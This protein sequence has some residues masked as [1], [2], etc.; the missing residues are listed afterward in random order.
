MYRGHTFR[1]RADR[2][3]ARRFS[4]QAILVSLLI[5]GV[6][7]FL[8]YTLSTTLASPY[9]T[10]VIDF[11]SMEPLA[12]AHPAATAPGLHKG[13][14]GGG[15]GGGGADT[16]PQPPRRLTPKPATRIAKKP[17]LP[18][19][20]AQEPHG[21]VPILAKPGEV[22]Q[23]PEQIY[24]PAREG[25]SEGTGTGQGSGTGSGT[26]S[27]SG[28]G[29]GSGTGSGSGSGEGS[30]MSVEQ[31]RKRYLAEHFAYIRDIIEKNLTY[32]PLAERN[33]WTGKVVVYFSVQRDGRVRD[34]RIV[35]SSGYDILDEKVIE[36]I[37]KVQPFPR[38]PVPAG[39]KIALSF[40]LE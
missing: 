22:H 26:G 13:A 10:V 38:P 12:P 9:R 40:G 14:G 30:G 33:G 27:G 35:K 20:T 32:P 29:S 16:R 6:A 39:L 17:S 21:S 7:V 8:V 36:T 24:Q 31:Q 37:R 5:H 18:P 2:P 3:T 34:I 25:A 11:T 4:R 28:S 23:T 19:S 1:S 15:G